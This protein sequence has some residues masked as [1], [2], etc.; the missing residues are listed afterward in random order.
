M[1]QKWASDR[2]NRAASPASLALDASVRW[3]SWKTPSR[4]HGK[5]TDEIDDETRNGPVSDILGEAEHTAR[6]RDM[7]LPEV[8]GLE[9]VKFVDGLP[10]LL[11]PEEDRV[12]VGAG[13]SIS[14]HNRNVA[15]RG[16]R[17]GPKAG[18]RRCGNTVQS[19]SIVGSTWGILVTK[20][21]IYYTT[22]TLS[23]LGV[24]YII[25]WLKGYDARVFCLASVGPRARASSDWFGY[26]P[27]ETMGT[28]LI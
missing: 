28:I 9:E 18:V 1:G 14:F 2:P 17:R 22:L 13:H 10:C 20:N 26:R 5:F 25:G 15:G 7:V 21:L 27:Q 8:G 11:K 3:L 6:F 23:P 24:K 16:G 4:V 12:N 19:R